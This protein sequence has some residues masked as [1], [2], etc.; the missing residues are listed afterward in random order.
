MQYQQPMLHVQQAVVLPIVLVQPGNQVDSITHA[1]G[2]V[3]P[4]SAQVRKHL[5][6]LRQQQSNSRRAS[7]NALGGGGGANPGT[8][9][10]AGL[11]EEAAGRLQ[12]QTASWHS[13]F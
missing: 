12:G 10:V 11:G 4:G 2:K 9:A 6:A 8:R 7:V 1:V 3:G 5:A 13:T